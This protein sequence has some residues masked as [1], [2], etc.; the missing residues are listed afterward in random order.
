MY[1]L[2]SF[3]M[4]VYCDLCKKVMFHEHNRV[5]F[6]GRVSSFYI[7]ASFLP[8]DSLHGQEDSFE[9]IAKKLLMP[10]LKFEKSVTED[11]KG[12]RRRDTKLYGDA[13]LCVHHFCYL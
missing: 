3:K 13:H 5:M 2:S 1:L 10:V 7:L 9:K 6:H 8:P 11:I 4:E 12:W